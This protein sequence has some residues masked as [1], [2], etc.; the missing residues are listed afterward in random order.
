MWVEGLRRHLDDLRD[1]TYE[2]AAGGERPARYAAAFELLTPVA[3]GVLQDMN[4]LLLA[5]SGE[6][7]VRSPE[8]DGQGGL[9]G[10]WL[11]TWPE[12]A[13]ARNRFTGERL[14]PVTLSAVFPSG[15]VHPHLV[16]G[17]RV[18]PG[19]PSIIAWPMQII[20][21]ADAN[22]HQQLLWALATAEVHD[23]IY[24]ATWRIIPVA[25]A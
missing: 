6:V 24:Q 18:D 23:R 25:T 15:F 21:V 22:R 10:S 2:D 7:S 17:G 16:A 11:L 19:A 4:A 14:A 13:K 5:G 1:D 12:L 3:L 20:T 8:S 9:I